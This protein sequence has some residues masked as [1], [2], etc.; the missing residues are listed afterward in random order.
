LVGE[1]DIKLT[2]KFFKF[3]YQNVETYIKKLILIG[4]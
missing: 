4:V 2:L 3:S 1:T